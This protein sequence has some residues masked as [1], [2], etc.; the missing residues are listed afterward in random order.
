MAKKV[1]K[2][3]ET[4][5]YKAHNKE[6]ELYEENCDEISRILKDICSY[7]YLS[8]DIKEQSF[9]YGSIRTL[10]GKTPADLRKLNYIKKSEFK[11]RRKPEGDENGINN[12]QIEQ[13]GSY[14]PSEYNQ[15]P[16]TGL[17]GDEITANETISGFN[18]F[19][20]F[21]FG[22]EE[23]TEQEDTPAGSYKY[24]RIYNGSIKIQDEKNVNI[25]MDQAEMFT[26]TKSSTVSRFGKIPS[27][28]SITTRINRDGF[29]KYIN[30]VL[31]TKV[32]KDYKVMPGWF[33]IPHGEEN[34]RVLL[35]EKNC[36]ASKQYSKGCK[37]FVFPKTYL[38]ESW[39]EKLDL[40]VVG[41]DHCI[42]YMLIWKL[43]IK[44]EET[45]IPE[46]IP[47][48]GL[49]AFKF[50]FRDGRLRDRPINIQSLKEKTSK[51]V[52]KKHQGKKKSKKSYKF[53]KST[54][55]TNPEMNPK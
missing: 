34:V 53:V 35:N 36:V 3:L 6:S 31:C 32:S 1:A 41:R 40:N 54:F 17:F 46:N 33:N 24:Y 38:E 18:E 20:K 27:S 5:V 43:S 25:N 21:G 55:E 9:T 50:K 45:I 29:K 51:K 12:I 39:L 7:I 44:D 42:M 10:F 47:I 2:Q 4:N 23:I 26:C 22:E 15:I 11:V 14:K 37:I 28:L 8:K 30:R 19:G 13:P 48:A 49:E 16:S 52:S